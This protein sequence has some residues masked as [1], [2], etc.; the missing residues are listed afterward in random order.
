MDRPSLIL[1][2]CEGQTEASYFKSLINNKRIRGVE[3]EVLKNQGQHRALINKCVRARKDYSKDYEEDEGNIEV[4]AVCDQDK[5]KF[6]YQDLLR[7]AEEKNVKLA[8]S[9]PQ[10]ETYLVQHFEFKNI[11]KSKKSLE[12]YLSVHTMRHYGTKYS[13]SNLFW[14][15]KMMD[16]TPQKIKEA[17]GNSNNFSNHTKVPFLTVQHLTERLLEL[18]L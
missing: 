18:A 3:I 2:L 5:R 8:F 6:D 17:I 4:W 7:Y 1:I 15:N 10:F 12:E 13:K 9:K 11:N 14:L 16:E